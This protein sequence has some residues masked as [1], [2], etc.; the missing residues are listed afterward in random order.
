MHNIAIAILSIGIV[1][2]LIMIA[3]GYIPKRKEKKEFSYLETPKIYFKDIYM[4]IMESIS[5]EITPKAQSLDTMI[6]SRQ[7]VSILT[8]NKNI[9]TLRE[10]FENNERTNVKIVLSGKEEISFEAVI[11]EINKTIKITTEK[12]IT[13][14]DLVIEICSKPTVKQV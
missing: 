10:L 5:D 13:E 12:N 11:I 6:L 8:E 7:V 4:G 9:K 1:F 14:I 2:C 3:P